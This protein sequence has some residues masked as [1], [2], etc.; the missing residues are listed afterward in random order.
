MYIKLIEFMILML[1]TY[2]STMFTTNTPYSFKSVY[3]S[4]LRTVGCGTSV[5][6][7]C[8]YVCVHVIAV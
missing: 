4:V 1:N 8:M 3:V 7:R 2:T 6:S 5:L